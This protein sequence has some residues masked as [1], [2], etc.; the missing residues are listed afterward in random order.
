VVVE[1]RRF[2]VDLVRDRGGNAAQ[3]AELRIGHQAAVD[4][5]SGDA[6]GTLGK[7]LSKISGKSPNYG[8]TAPVCASKDVT[9]AGSEV[10]GPLLS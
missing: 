4:L 8:T 6:V 7:W 10:S 9:P 2:V 3:V 5:R 1:Q